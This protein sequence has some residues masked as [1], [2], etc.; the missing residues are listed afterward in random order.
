M[1]GFKLSSDETVT[2]VLG[3]PPPPPLLSLSLLP[4]LSSSRT[5]AHTH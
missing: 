4:P 5:H 2:K 1:Y 3:L